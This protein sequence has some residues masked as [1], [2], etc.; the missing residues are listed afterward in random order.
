[1]DVFYKRFVKFIVKEHGE[2]THEKLGCV[3]SSS[4][5]FAENNLQ[6][7]DL[8]GD[9]KENWVIDAMDRL[10]HEKSGFHI[11]KENEDDV[12]N[13]EDKV[14]ILDLEEILRQMIKEICKSSKKQIKIN[15][16][17]V[18]KSIGLSSSISSISTPPAQPVKTVPITKLQNL[19]VG[20][21]IKL[22]ESQISLASID[23]N[24]KEPP[25]KNKKAP[26]GSLFTKKKDK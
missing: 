11:K 23:V 5:E 12:E 15:G 20:K 24:D 22:H 6:I 17:A 10:W 16:N 2:P 18:D 25:A 26:S 8:S 7:N 4:M 13:I 19:P 14:P 3:L 1:M 9:E 21:E